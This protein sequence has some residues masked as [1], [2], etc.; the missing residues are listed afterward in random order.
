[1]TRLFCGELWLGSYLEP[2]RKNLFWNVRE[3][4]LR[5]AWRLLVF[6]VILFVAAAVDGRVRAGLAGRL[7]DL[8]EDLVRA[9]VFTLLIAAALY[10]GSR[11]VDH[12]RMRD[13]GF[14]FSRTWWI[15]LGFGVVLGAL[16]L[17]GV[18]AV[19]LAVG[20]VTVTGSFV[21]AAGQPFVATILFGVVAV[22]AVAFGETEGSKSL[23]Y[24]MDLARQS[25][26]RSLA[27]N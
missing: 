22:A 10:L 21:P 8:Y 13:Y 24:S 27:E 14:H 23:L 20:W 19:E 7:P 11:V 5:A 26:S 18:L 2:N 15:D 6:L 9:L 1:M 12:R 4:R 17:F 16:L 25:G 3:R